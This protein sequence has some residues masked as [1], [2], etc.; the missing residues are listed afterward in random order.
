VHAL[1]AAPRPVSAAALADRLWDDPPPSARKTVQGHASPERSFLAT[2][3]GL[4]GALAGGA[5]GYRLDA[6]EPARQRREPAQPD[7]S[8]PVAQVVPEEVEHQRSRLHAHLLGPGRA[9]PPPRVQDRRRPSC[10]RR[11][12][13]PAAGARLS[14]AARGNHHG[15]AVEE[16]PSRVPRG[17][18]VF[19]E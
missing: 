10:I 19:K 12:P 11:I 18:H 8:A 3:G 2:A 7:L 16:A 5:T 15:P 6:E 4:G 17:H 13:G 14:I 9:R 1:L